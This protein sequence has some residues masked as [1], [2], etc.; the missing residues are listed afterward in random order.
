MKNF[1]CTHCDQ[2]VFFENVSCVNCGR[3]LGFLPDWLRMGSF[4]VQ[5]EDTW[6]T[7]D[8]SVWRPCA[9]YAREQVC[10]WMVPAHEN[11]AFC[12][13]CRLNTT[14]PDLSVPGNRTHWAQM[15]LAKRRMLYTLL[16]L[17]LPLRSKRADP[18]RGL[19]FSFLVSLPGLPV[20]TGHDDGHIVIDLAEADD[21]HREKTRLALHEPYRTLLGH[22]RHEIGHYY[23][24]RLVDDGP[25]L[26]GF[27]ALFGDER[28]D[29]GD[30]L[31]RHYEQGPPA[32]WQDSFVTS[33]ATMHPWED[34]AE[35]WA[36]FMHIVDTLDTA[37]SL[38]LVLQPDHDEEPAMEL[39]ADR[40]RNAL[41]RNFD[42]MR[43]QW[44]PLTYALNSLNRSMGLRDPY[45]F[46]LS[47]PAMQKLRFVHQVI[48]A[49]QDL[50]G[51]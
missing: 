20:S 50:P 33:Y 6:A 3:V 39:G 32:D 29:Y 2:L 4:D 31:R 15:E 12:V 41:A 23:W 21:A 18:A 10:N 42:E 38:G 36:H 27:R 48:Q 11:E 1:H 35:S 5:A 28:A 19:A 24:D 13:A 43:E 44:L 17:Q 16:A 7:P 34:W 45:P 30:A 40:R 8:G 9:N 37:R 14:I 47:A 26:D 46:V 51:T 49:S 25:F 22:F